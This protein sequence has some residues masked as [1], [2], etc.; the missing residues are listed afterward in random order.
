LDYTVLAMPE[1]LV[2]LVP[3]APWLG[4]VF[5]G[6]DYLR[7]ASRGEAAERSTAWAAS[8]GSGVALLLMVVLDLLAVIAGAPGQVRLM[9]W[10]VSGDYE[11]WV[12][13]TLDALSL[14]LATIVALVGFLT[15]RFSVSYMHREEGFQ[16]F[17]LVLS[18]FVGAMLLIVLAGNAVLAFVGWELA[19]VSS[20][21][22]IGYAYDRRVPTQNAMRA[23]VTN[24]IGDTAFVTGIFLAFAWLGGVEWPAIAAGAQRVEGLGV[25]LV[26]L[27][28][29]IAALAKSAQVPFAPWILRALEGPTPSSAIFYGSLMVHAGVY[30]IIRLAP[31]FEQAPGIMA[32]LALLGLL[33]ALYGYLAGL[34][35]TDAKGSLMLSTTAQVGL[36]FLACGLG[37]FTLAAWYLG[38]HALWR[39]YQF[40]SA[41]GLMQQVSGPQRPVALWLAR[42]RKLYTASLQR[43]WLEPLADA[44]LV[45]PT[46]R[47]ARDVQV[48]DERV[49]HRIIGQ[50]EQ[51]AA[52]A[53]LAEWEA[54]KSGAPTSPAELT[55]AQGAVGRLLLWL[56]SVLHWFEERLV[57]RGGGE[58]L[59]R[60]LRRAGR[61]LERVDELLSQPRY[62]LLMIMAT[63][64]VIL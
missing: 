34:T 21:L 51:D 38:A 5:V 61:L 30:L 22:L 63:F 36:M 45:R 33:T 48:F 1:F 32:L 4:S 57:V 14:P 42:S 43:F 62:L 40:L 24:R 41:P 17:F 35:Q 47:L 20:Y 50:P 16:R 28:F 15:V 58:V 56:A 60:R 18:L 27:A 13:F 46:Q 44:L 59:G 53:S 19:G 31:L 11:V 55:G 37:G 54:R 7:G 23:F 2:W 49:V 3:L 10:L 39:S 25:G 52:I 29:L 26:A 6:V 64:V 9:P 8:L 12:S